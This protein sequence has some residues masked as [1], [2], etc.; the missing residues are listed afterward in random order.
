MSRTIRQT[1]RIVSELSL[2]MSVVIMH[3]TIG[4]ISH[5]STHL[6]FLIVIFVS[7]LLLLPQRLR[8]NP[9]FAF[10]IVYIGLSLIILNPPAVFSPWARFALFIAVITIASPML[11]SPNLRLFRYKCLNSILV[12]SVVISV[13]SFVFYFLGINFMQYS[14]DLEF[15]EKGGL[16]GGLTNHSIVLGILSGISTCFLV[17]KGLTHNSKWLLMVVP[18]FGSLLFSASRGALLATVTGMIS[19]IIMTYRLHMSKIKLW[20]V[21]SIAIVGMWYVAT[22]TM[23]L[24]GLES[25]MSDRNTATLLSS[26]EAKIIYRLEEFKSSPLI[27]IGFSTISLDGGDDVNLSTGTIEPGSSWLSLFSMTGIIGALFFIVILVKSIRTQ[28]AEKTHRSVLLIGLLSFFSVSMFSEGYI[29][30]AGSPL[31]YILWL[32]I[33]NSVDSNYIKKVIA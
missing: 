5:I 3:K 25:K 21:L 27:G 29:F 15:T 9:M 13:I 26:R 22:N 1:N 30:A 2:F 10:F 7:I 11:Q 31:C 16:F 17:Y 28:M 6:F 8:L 23:V 4:L 32:T 18:C 24:S 14:A 19:I 33:G 20:I 12:M